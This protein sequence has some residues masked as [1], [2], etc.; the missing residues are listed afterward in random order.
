MTSVRT[1]YSLGSLIESATIQS[2]LEGLSTI[3]SKEF[4]HHLF[5]ILFSFFSIE[6]QK[7]LE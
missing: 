2:S 5:Y 1:N 6:E 3:I 7:V 4:Q